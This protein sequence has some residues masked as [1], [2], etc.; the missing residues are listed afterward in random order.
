[1]LVLGYGIAE[2]V[3]QA[4]QGDEHRVWGSS[5]LANHTMFSTMW[6]DSFIIDLAKAKGLTNLQL[7][8]SPF[9]FSHNSIWE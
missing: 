3:L 5:L 6:L 8:V 9:L 2:M 1:L 4:E 7:K